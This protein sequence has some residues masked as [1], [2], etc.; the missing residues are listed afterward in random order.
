M[1]LAVIIPAYNHLPEVMTCL[2]SLRDLRTVDDADDFHVQDDASP[3]VFYPACIPPEIA[4]VNRNVS[5][6]GFGANCNAG[7]RE[8]IERYQPDVLVFVN[9][10]ISGSELWSRSWDTAILKAFAGE[11][12][13]VV[14]PRLLFPNGAVQSAG[15]T[16]DQLCQPVHRC[17][18]WSNP[19]DPQVSEARDVEWAT[20]AVLAVQT[21]WFQSLNGFD[22]RYERGYWE[23]VD[24]C[25]R[26]REAGARIRYEPACTLIHS[27]GSTGGSP[28]FA[29]N[30]R[31]FKQQWVDT[32]KV[33]AGTLMPIQR[34]W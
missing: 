15:G 6:V 18:G 2:N 26:A 9:Q 28:Y 14:A 27:V 25:M 33:K 12:V 10:D 16:W 13:G 17:L 20:G 21:T 1:S 34:F 4:S 19:H 31:R 29:R 7:A 24:F 8:A 32:G 23:D 11:Q 30:A 3:E 22:E 5:N